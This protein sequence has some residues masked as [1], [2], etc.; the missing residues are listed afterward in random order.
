L[1]RLR[2]FA[3][4]AIHSVCQRVLNLIM[5]RRIKSGDDEGGCQ[6]YFLRPASKGPFRHLKW[7]R[8]RANGVIS[9]FS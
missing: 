4:P 5:D 3:C 1:G 6:V 2:K 7:A 9:I 8:P